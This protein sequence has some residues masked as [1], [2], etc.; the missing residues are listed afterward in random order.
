MR[1]IGGLLGRS[2]FGPIHEQMTKVCECVK[3]L[4][5]LIEAF[6]SGDGGG[7]HKAILAID[8]LEGE[9][10]DVKAEMRSRLSASFFGSAERADMLLLVNRIDAVA[11]ECQEVGKLIDLRETSVD[12]EL[13]PDIE[14][15]TSKVVETVCTLA[16]ATGL[17]KQILE[18]SFASREVAKVIE[19]IERVNREEFE[20]DVLEKGALKKLFSLEGKLDPTTVMFLMRIIQSIG[21]VADQAE[22]ASDGIRLMVDK[23]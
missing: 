7:E 15:L 19:L 21:R 14:A 4:K 2:P 5:D 9:A 11:D 17:L 20:A 10:D 16:R 8:K 23:R 6:A 3:V 12:E 13:A 1:K 18:S 22:N